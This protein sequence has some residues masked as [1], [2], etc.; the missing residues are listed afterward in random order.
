MNAF[1]QAALSFTSQNLGAGKLERIK[2]IAA[3]SLFSVTAVGVIFGNLIVFFG[4]FFMGIYSDNPMV[5]SA[6]IGRLSIICR[7]YALCGIMDVTCG[8][9][10]GMGASFM[11][12]TV[13]LL[14]ACGLRL[15]WI[16]T[17]FRQEQ[18]HSLSSL[19]ISYP[20]SWTI[21]FSAHFI[22]FMYIYKKLTKKC[23]SQ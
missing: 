15:L 7:F 8:C 5:I 22:C 12:M 6:G 13:S 23:V 20:I 17:I 1:Y 16:A 11:P 3:A 14:G 4:N 2:K 10:R 19:Y 9:L 21:T 18:F